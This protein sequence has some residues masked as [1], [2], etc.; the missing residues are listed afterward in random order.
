MT[1]LIHIK[2]NMSRFLVA[3]SDIH[4]KKACIDDLFEKIGFA[5]EGSGESEGIL[6]TLG[7]YINRGEDSAG[8]IERLIDGIPH[9]KSI[10]LTGNHDYAFAQAIMQVLDGDRDAPHIMNWMQTGS[11][12]AT[13]ESYGIKWWSRRREPLSDQDERTLSWLVMRELAVRMPANHIRWLMTLRPRYETRRAHFVHAGMRPGVAPD[14]QNLLDMLHIEEEFLE[15]REGFGKPVY[16]GHTISYCPEDTGARVSLDTG[17]FLTGIVTAAIVGEDGRPTRFLAGC[18]IQ[19]EP[20]FVDVVHHD[21]DA[22]FVMWADWALQ[23]AKAWGRPTVEA[24]I[25]NGRRAAFLGRAFEREGIRI[26]R[27]HIAD[28][29]AEYRA[30]GGR[31]GL[32]AEDGQTRMLLQSC[33]KSLYN[34]RSASAAQE[35]SSR[36]GHN[37]CH[38]D[39]AGTCRRSAPHADGR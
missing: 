34:F 37:S 7:D 20:V 24:C 1:R 23:V 13:L 21:V 26:E 39:D 19:R 29:G 14:K 32:N 11:T 12:K 10:N 31:L 27:T 5:L 25:Q 8:V 36:E 6:V 30:N 3:V 33:S 17:S 35:R 9:M 16:H 38:A 22:K 18:D 15:D 4:G 2:V 28:L